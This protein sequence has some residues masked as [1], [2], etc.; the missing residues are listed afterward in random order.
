MR[1]LVT[2]KEHAHLSIKSLALYAQ[3][4]GQVFASPSSWGRLIRARGWARPRERLEPPRPRVG[5]R[6]A[7][8][9]A[10]WHIDVTTLKLL[11]GSRA[12]I[13]AVIDNFSRKILAYEVTAGL[14]TGATE[15][16]L[17]YALSLVPFSWG[18][19]IPTALS[20]SGVEN[21]GPLGRLAEQGLLEHLLA[22]IDVDFSNSMIERWFMSLKHRWLHL[23]ELPD[24]E[25]VRR[26]IDRFVREY[27]CDIPHSALHGWTPNEVYFKLRA[28]LPAELAAARAAARAARIDANRRASCDSCPLTETANDSRHV[29][30]TNTS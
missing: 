2:A 24:L 3:R 11:D 26:L 23:H 8:P 12:Y 10:L 21:I 28:E 15:S 25:T 6:A 30:R 9:N 14:S 29:D 18:S 27:N 17:R 22:Q 4:M 1:A 19:S 7:A 16:V 5:L 13:H 20:D